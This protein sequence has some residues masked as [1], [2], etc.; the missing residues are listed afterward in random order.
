M[1]AP[2]I[3]GNNMFMNQTYKLAQTTISFEIPKM[4]KKSNA[5]NSLMPRSLRTWKLGINDF[6]INTSDIPE[7]S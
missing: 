6:A 5:A 7:A 2:T 4:G 3:E 1:N